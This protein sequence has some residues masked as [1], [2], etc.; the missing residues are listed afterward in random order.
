MTKDNT[1]KIES[2]FNKIKKRFVNTSEKEQ[3]DI[4]DK[5]SEIEK[6]AKEINQQRLMLEAEVHINNMTKELNILKAG[7]TKYIMRETVQE[8]IKKLSKKNGGRQLAFTDL[9][10]F[11]RAIP[12]KN[13]ELIKKAQKYFDHIYI[14]YTANKKEIEKEKIAKDPIAFGVV[15]SAE[16]NEYNN[17]ILK[18]DIQ[19]ESQHMF[20]ITDWVDEY[21][22]LTLDKLIELSKQEL[23]KNDIL[24][25]TKDFVELVGTKTEQ[26]GD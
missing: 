8:L 17:E 22:D 16:N 14:L 11:P 25:T 23:Q 15:D 2:L 18:Y 1:N 13:K 19:S 20:F 4:I 10:N 3:N 5:L 26:C 7:Y 24:K 6:N 21:C 12:T 9:E